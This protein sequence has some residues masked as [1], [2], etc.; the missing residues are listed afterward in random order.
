MKI[1]FSGRYSFSTPALIVFLTLICL[2]SPAAKAIDLLPSELEGWRWYQSTLLG[3][4]AKPFVDRAIVLDIPVPGSSKRLAVRVWRVQGSAPKG[5][6]LILPGTGGNSAS[7]NSNLLAEEVNA[8]GYDAIVLANPFTPDF[9][10]T[11]SSDGLIGFP[12][13]DIVDTVTMMEAAVDSYTHYYGKYK[14][15]NLMGYSL[16]ALYTVLAAG[17]ESSLT[18][19]KLIA[20]NP[21]ID[22]QYAMDQLDGM[23]RLAINDPFSAPRMLGDLF[24]I[25]QKTKG[26]VLIE[27]ILELK[28]LVPADEAVGREA[29]GKIFQNNLIEITRGLFSTS[30]VFS[31]QYRKRQIE[32][33]MRSITFAQYLGYAGIGISQNAEPVRKTFAAMVKDINLNGILAALPSTKKIY[34]ITNNDDFLSTPAELKRLGDILHGNLHVFNAGG[35]CGNYW[36]PSF[37][38]VLAGIINQ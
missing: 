2:S 37:K 5:L 30:T 25:F 3:A 33:K 27:K 36:A 34:V 38:K 20:L 26:G 7:S 15:L 16:G 28:Q 13:R 23:I 8:L 12:R 19:H 35:H 11:F 4:F 21:P 14:S 10:S 31:T 17:Q 22:L 24:R 9:Q 1:S 18:F 29:I 6:F 32:A